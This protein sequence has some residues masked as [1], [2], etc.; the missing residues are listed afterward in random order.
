VQ[1]GQSELPFTGFDDRIVV[2]LGML[3]LLLGVS[4]RLIGRRRYS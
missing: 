1:S 4:L 3:T 2:L